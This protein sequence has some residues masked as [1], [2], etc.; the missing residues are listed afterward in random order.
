M[1]GREGLCEQRLDG[2]MFE[3]EEGG[4][5]G[6]QELPCEGRRAALARPDE[7][8][9][10]APREALADPGEVSLPLDHG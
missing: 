10:R 3:V 7:H 6:G 8:D 2:R 4:S 5:L 9:D 1:E